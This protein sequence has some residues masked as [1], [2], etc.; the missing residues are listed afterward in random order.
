MNNNLSGLGQRNQ[1]Y[2]EY[3]GGDSSVTTNIATSIEQMKSAFINAKDIFK[4]RREFLNNF[5]E[6]LVMILNNGFAKVK[7]MFYQKYQGRL[8]VEMQKILKDI[9]AKFKEHTYSAPK[10]TKEDL[11]TVIQAR[12]SDLKNA[13]AGIGQKL[14]KR[15]L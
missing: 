8:T 15:G 7:E 13:E 12:I 9:A 4:A 1:G 3:E 2:Y 5:I 6:R 11:D 10:N 14:G